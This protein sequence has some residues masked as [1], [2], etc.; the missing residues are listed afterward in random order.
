MTIN[1]E[2][3]YYK[4]G[5]LIHRLETRL[6]RARVSKEIA[7]KQVAIAIRAMDDRQLLRHKTAA[8]TLQVDRLLASIGK[9][10]EE[11]TKLKN[12]LA[13]YIAKEQ[14]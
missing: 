2:A 4:H 12:E 10:I 6:H 3:E 5:Q 1:F 7:Q 13:F 9:L 11:N 8:V 14:M